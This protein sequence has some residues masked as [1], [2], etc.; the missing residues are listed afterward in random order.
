MI[1]SGSF[2]DD[3]WPKKKDGDG[4]DTIELTEAAKKIKKWHEIATNEV[5]WWDHTNS[6]KIV[7][8]GRIYQEAYKNV[9]VSYNAGARS[10]GISGYQFRAP[11]EW[12]A[13]L[14]AAWH[15][16]PKKLKLMEGK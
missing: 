15:I 5:I 10:R 16:K 7:L 3:N 13:E 12:F 9:W 11:G 2:D 4:N 6:M 8:G 1:R 14:Y